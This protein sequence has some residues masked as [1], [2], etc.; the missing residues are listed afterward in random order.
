MI[1]GIVLLIFIF[2]VQYWYI[3]ME[4]VFVCLSCILVSANTKK[5]N[6]T[7]RLERNNIF[8]ICR[9]QDCQHRKSQGLYS[10]QTNKQTNSLNKWVQQSHRM[11]DKHTKTNSIFI[12]QYWTQKIKIKSTMPFIIA[13]KNEY[14]GI[15]LTEYAGFVCWKLQYADERNQRRS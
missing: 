8:L 1:N 7:C 6:T 2:C 15:N 4:L 13:L 5:G 11:Q 14:L 10:K 9:R 3:K 12:Y